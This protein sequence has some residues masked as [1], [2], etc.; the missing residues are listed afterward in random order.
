MSKYGSQQYYILYFK[1][2]YQVKIITNNII[3]TK[4]NNI[5]K[6]KINKHMKIKLIFHKNQIKNVY[7]VGS[8]WS[9]FG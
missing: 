7:Y 8:N 5:T 6:L 9:K 1:S 3:T 2:L 4:N